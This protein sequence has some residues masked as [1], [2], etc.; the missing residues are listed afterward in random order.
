MEMFGKFCFGVL[1]VF[2]ASL[3]GGFVFMKIWE[4]FIVYAFHVKSLNLIESL[5]VSFFISATVKVRLDKDE[6]KDFI[7]H[8]EDSI[9]AILMGGMILG[10]GYILTLFQ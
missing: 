2:V 5:G 6:E 8:V 3:F 10:L 4:W 9:K 7:K 1:M